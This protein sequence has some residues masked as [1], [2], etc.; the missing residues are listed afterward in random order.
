MKLNE[1]IHLVGVAVEEQMKALDREIPEQ[2]DKYNKLDEINSQLV[3]AWSMA[4]DLEDEKPIGSLTD[5][6]K[7][8]Y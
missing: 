3:L 2:E 1:K 5:L 8:K 4:F 6:L 7:H